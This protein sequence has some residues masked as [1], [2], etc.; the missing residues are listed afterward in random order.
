MKK[1]R[2]F[3]YGCFFYF[4]YRSW[5]GKPSPPAASRGWHVGSCS[6]WSP[7]HSCTKSIAPFFVTLG[8]RHPVHEHTLHA[9]SYKKQQELGSHTLDI[10]L[11]WFSWKRGQH[12][13]CFNYCFRSFAYH[14]S[15]MPPSTSLCWSVILRRS[16][17]LQHTGVSYF[18]Y[19]TFLSL[20]HST[21]RNNSLRHLLPDKLWVRFRYT[22]RLPLQ[23][24]VS[25]ATI[26]SNEIV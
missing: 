17:I 24:V 8:H 10:R 3:Q 16:G 20:L 26:H 21:A 23:I 7:T 14:S 19:C 6:C 4:T 1:Q 5:V 9:Y 13:E 2:L 22:Y 12:V 18:R 11:L 25:I 15:R